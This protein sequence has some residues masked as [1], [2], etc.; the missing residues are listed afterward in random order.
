MTLATVLNISTASRSRSN[1]DPVAGNRYGWHAQFGRALA[2]RLPVTVECWTVDVALTTTHDETVDGIRY[3]VFRSD[4]FIAPNREWSTALL[5]ALRLEVQNPK[6]IVHLHDVHSWLAYV[7]LRTVARAHVISHHHGASR[8]PLRRLSSWRKLPFAPL[9]LTEQLLENQALRS[10]RH[11][12]VVNSSS[13]PYFQQHGVAT[14]F[15]PMAPNLEQLS[16]R[17][18]NEARRDLELSP[19][20]TI[21]LSVGGFS[22][23]KNLALLADVFALLAH[24]QPRARL[25]IAGHTFDAAYRATIEQRLTRAGLRDCVTILGHVPRERLS[26]YYAAADALLITSTA[27]EGGPMPALE[28]CALGTPVIATPVGFVNDFAARAGGGITATGFNPN[29]YARDLR[30]LL[31]INRTNRPNLLWTWDNVARTV[32]PIYEKLIAP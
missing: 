12:F 25:I 18:R 28:A 32:E 2:Q 30:K 3:R 11:C 14:T 8:P 17:E 10:L 4:R 22:R 19:S 31:A 21:L 23:P 24:E 5:A 29:R 15:C 20:D 1:Q 13:A 9:F 27:D 16:R 7:V 6:T 26:N